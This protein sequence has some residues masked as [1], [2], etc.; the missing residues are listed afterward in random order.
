[1]R[2]PSGFVGALAGLADPAYLDGQRRIAPGIG[3]LFG[4]R[5]PLLAAVQRGFRRGTK[6]RPADATPVRGRS[7]LPRARARGPL[8]PVRHPAADARGRGRADAGS[9]CGAPPARPATGSPSTRWP[10]R[11]GTGIRREPYR[12]AE[13]EQLVY[14]PSR[15]E[16]RLVGSTIATLTHGGRRTGHDPELPRRALALL[17]QLIGDAEPDVQKALSW[18]YRSLASL[19]PG[20]TTDALAAQDGDA[21]ATADGHRAWVDP[22]LAGQA[23]SAR[24]PKRSAS[25]SAGIRKRPGAPATSLASEISTRFGELPDPVDPSRAAPHLIRQE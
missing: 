12:W 3:A 4:V 22:R 11:I 10:T 5:W 18:A 23:R 25:D 15:W 17:E 14:S 13:L 2:S 6:R 16:R 21:A 1:M 8:V 20:A 7:A 9:S 19:D 24:P